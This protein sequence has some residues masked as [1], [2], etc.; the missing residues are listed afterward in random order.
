[1]GGWGKQRFHL[2]PITWAWK[3]GATERWKY[4]SWLVEFR[5]CWSAGNSS[6]PIQLDPPKSDLSAQ[7]HWLCLRLCSVHWPRHKDVKGMFEDS[8]STQITPLTQNS[9]LGKNKF[10]TVEVTMNR[11]L[12]VYMLILVLESTLCTI[13]KWE[14]PVEMLL[15][16]NH[17]PLC[18]KKNNLHNLRNTL[19]LDHQYEVF[20][21]NQRQPSW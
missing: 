16:S 3:S 19:G 15:K 20:S 7:E 21:E 18:D 5:K 13:L 8:M 4:A 10:S 1:M 12:L 2:H 6:N 11:V 14:I 9:K 17:L